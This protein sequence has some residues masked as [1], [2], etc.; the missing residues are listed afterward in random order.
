MFGFLAD[1]L[2]WALCREREEEARSIRPHTAKRPDTERV[3]RE[4]SDWGYWVALA[5][6]GG[7]PTARGYR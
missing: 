5:L 2:V 1:E 6:R 3:I 4:R 7:S